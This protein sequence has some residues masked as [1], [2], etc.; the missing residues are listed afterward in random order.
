MN[1]E[2]PI[3]CIKE[4]FPHQGNYEGYLKDIQESLIK[5]VGAGKLFNLDL[6]HGQKCKMLI[7]KGDCDCTPSEFKIVETEIPYI[8]QDAYLNWYW[9]HHGMALNPEQMK[10]ML[11]LRGTVT[12]IH[13]EP[14]WISRLVEL[15]DK[16][17]VQNF[18]VTLHTFGE[19]SGLPSGNSAYFKQ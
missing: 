10:V 13:H 6:E 17:K 9:K 15:K 14:Y 16:E 18:T 2:K 3:M 11:R 4:G 5:K 7:G 19:E 8:L 1:Q 12:I